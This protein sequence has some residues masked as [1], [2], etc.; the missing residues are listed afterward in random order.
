MAQTNMWL[1]FSVWLYNVLIA[2]GSFLLS[3]APCSVQGWTLTLLVAIIPL[4][5]LPAGKMKMRSQ[6]VTFIRRPKFPVVIQLHF[7]GENCVPGHIHLK[8]EQQKKEA[9]LI[10]YQQQG[11][12]YWAGISSG[13]HSECVLCAKLLPL[14]LTLCDPMECSPPGSSVYGNSPGKNTGVGCYAL[15]LRIFLD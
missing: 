3:V 15:L 10:N 6:R 12:S 8:K 1:F 14:Y 4:N 13:C 5:T 7:S 2:L 11:R 9:L